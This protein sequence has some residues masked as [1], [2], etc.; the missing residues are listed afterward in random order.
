MSARPKRSILASD[1]GQIRSPARQALADALAARDAESARRDEAALAVERMSTLVA[2]AEAK[3]MQ[4]SAVAKTQRDQYAERIAESAKSG[5]PLLAETAAV[6]KARE[7]E[8]IAQDELSAAQQ[9]EGMAQ[10]ALGAVQKRLTEAVAAIEQAADD[11]IREVDVGAMLAE[12]EA[13]QLRLMSL[14]L[15]HRYFRKHGLYPSKEIEKRIEKLHHWELPPPAGAA[16]FQSFDRHP[17]YADW[18]NSRL[19]LQQNADALLPT[20]PGHQPLPLG[21]DPDI[22]RDAHNARNAAIAV[23]LLAAR[24][25]VEAAE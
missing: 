13:V 12:M 8:L 1:E 25:A 20:D 22:A 10:A 11:V 23:R 5:L 15:M 24:D 19:A 18:E 14:R 4:A 9:A 21:P 7:S 17:R 6:R 16:E 2:E 3:C